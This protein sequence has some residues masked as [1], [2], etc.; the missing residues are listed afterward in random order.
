MLF[1]FGFASFPI[2]DGL[3]IDCLQGMN[4]V[5]GVQIKGYSYIYKVYTRAIDECDYSGHGVFVFVFAFA[6]A[7]SNS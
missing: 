5:E 4:R 7:F 2:S 3:A 1:T 6:F